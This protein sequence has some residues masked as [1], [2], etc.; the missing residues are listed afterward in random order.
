[1]INWDKL[2]KEV[3][4]KKLDP[5]DDRIL[6]LVANIFGYSEEGKELLKLISKKYLEAPVCPH[7]KPASY[8]YYRDGQNSMV[9]KIK[10]ILE[11]SKRK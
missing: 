10:K 1:M 5:D 3:E 6:T 11:I 4:G 2:K 7:D 8:G 9:L